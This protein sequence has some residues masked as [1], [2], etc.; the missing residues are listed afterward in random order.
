[1]TKH[2]VFSMLSFAVLLWLNRCLL[3]LAS[4]K[5]LCVRAERSSI[6]SGREN[7]L[8]VLNYKSKDGG[9][10]KAWYDFYETRGVRAGVLSGFKC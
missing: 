9:Y 6:Y 10:S 4:L 5:P 3:A 1:M 7:E 8:R 2:L